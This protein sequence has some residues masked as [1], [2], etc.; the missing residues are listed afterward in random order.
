MLKL[1]WRSGAVKVCPG[2]ALAAKTLQLLVSPGVCPCLALSR[3]AEAEL[4]ALLLREPSGPFGCS[5][6]VSS[7]SISSGCS[8]AAQQARGQTSPSTPQNQEIQRGVLGAGAALS[9]WGPCR[10]QPAVAAP[11]P[12]S[13]AS[14]LPWSLLG[15]P[16]K[17]RWLGLGSLPVL[18]CAVLAQPP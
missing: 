11:F 1:G 3:G 16:T 14:N 10:A 18:A 17:E 5:K 15:D 13:L 9:L 8:S 6:M 7:V 4:Q 12:A 2:H